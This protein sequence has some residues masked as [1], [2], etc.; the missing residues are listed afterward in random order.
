[1]KLLV[2]VLF[3]ALLSCSA[4]HAD[5]PGVLLEVHIPS[6]AERHAKQL[7]VRVR[8]GR[9]GALVQRDDKT[10]PVGEWPAEVFLQ[11][12]DVTRAWSA[13]V[14]VLDGDSNELAEGSVDGE[15][16][17]REV[18]R[19]SLE[20]EASEVDEQVDEK[21]DAGPARDAAAAPPKDAGLA[22]PDAAAGPK[23]AGHAGNDSAIAAP[24]DAGRTAAADAAATGPTIASCTSTPI[25]PGG[26]R[27]AACTCQRCGDEANDCYASPDQVRAK[28]CGAIQACAATNHCTGDACYCGDS[29]LCL[30][31]NGA[32]RSEIET[33]AGTTDPLGVQSQS[34][35]STNAWGLSKTLLACQLERCEVECGL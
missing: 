16:R 6:S 24:T 18:V 7:R 1:M 4:E 10:V 29:L 5:V 35:S 25:D 27:C 19:V 2:A 22:K 9:P 15:F 20:V 26:A 32:C 14:W 8:S 28:Q 17:P 31:P 34:S 13:E 12:T 30:N 21:H 33:A 3:V 11:A 23:D